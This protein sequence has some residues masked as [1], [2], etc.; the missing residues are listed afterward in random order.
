MRLGL[1][2]V[3]RGSIA[4]SM[5]TS[6]PSPKPIT[7][8][9]LSQMMGDQLE[10]GLGASPPLKPNVPL[11]GQISAT[12]KE[13]APQ[14]P[15]GHTA[16]DSTAIRSYKYDPQTQEFEAWPTSGDTAYRYGEVSP[17]AAKVFQDAPSKGKGV[18]ADQEQRHSCGKAGQREVGPCEAGVALDDSCGLLKIAE[19]RLTAIT[20]RK[21]PATNPK[22]ISIPATN[23]N[24]PYVL[25]PSN[26]RSSPPVSST[27]VLN[28]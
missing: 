3:R 27:G 22:K 13:A 21:Y 25:I 18:S 10:K 17:D 23:I 15:E 12:M 16:V 26:T 19:I 5:Q 7:R 9:S 14:L 24:P 20:N 1:F 8:G 28:S 11:R 2:P 6:A 4:E